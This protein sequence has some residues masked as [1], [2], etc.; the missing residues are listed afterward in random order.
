MSKLVFCLLLVGNLASICTARS[1][2]VF[3]GGEKFV[4][5][6][7]SKKAVILAPTDPWT[8]D[9]TIRRIVLTGSLVNFKI[10]FAV[11]GRS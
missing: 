5:K 4:S 2:L 8:E 10:L 7:V 1:L 6:N 3:Y 11:I 9:I